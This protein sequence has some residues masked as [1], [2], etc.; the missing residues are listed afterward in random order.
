MKNI[1]LTVVLTTALFSQDPANVPRR[2]LPPPK[3]EPKQPKCHKVKIRQCL[4]IY[5]TDGKPTGKCQW[6]DFETEVC[7]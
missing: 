3:E 6:M 1:L 7:E 2:S 4:E 5:D